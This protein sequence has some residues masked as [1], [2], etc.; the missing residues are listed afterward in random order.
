MADFTQILSQ[1]EQGDS[2][3]SEQL[4]PL[5]YEELRKLAEAKMADENPEHTLQATA[6]VHEAYLRLANAEQRRK[7][8]G[9]QHFLAVASIAMRQVL[10]DWARKKGALKRGGQMRRVE[11][12]DTELMSQARPDTVLAID[13]AL[14]Q[15]AQRNP[16][17]AR[18]V[19]LRLFSGLTLVDIAETLGISK[20]EVHRRWLYARASLH[21]SIQNES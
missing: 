1:I 5:V 18:L 10:V 19:E 13:E 6:L 9:R 3:A 2:N 8:T 14:K 21:D 15:L 11:L 16:E 4:L 7:W 12:D 20:S 17:A